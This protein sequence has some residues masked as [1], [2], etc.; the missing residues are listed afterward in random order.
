MVNDDY[1]IKKLKSNDE[2]SINQAFNLIYDKYYKLVSFCVSQYVKS[3][4]DVEEIV[5]DTFISFFDNINKLDANKNLKYYILTI[6]KNNAINHLKKSRNY[7]SYSDDILADIPYE[8]NYQSNDI[9]D[10]L[11][12]VLKKD[13]LIIIVKYLIYGY[14]FKEIAN[15]QN[16]SINT[17]MSKYRRSIKKAYDYFKESDGHE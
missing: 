17:I 3:K 6:A 8:D 9:I 13:E 2:F 12:N 7:I 1:I 5:D 15:E 16:I 10:S 11:K 14:S 4:E